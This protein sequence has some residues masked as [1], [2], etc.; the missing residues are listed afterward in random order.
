MR[1][2][3]ATLA[4]L[5][6]LVLA[7]P[8]AVFADDC[9]KPRQSVEAARDAR[10]KAANR[11]ALLRYKA[12]HDLFDLRLCRPEW[13]CPF[14]TELQAEREQIVASAQLQGVASALAAVGSSVNVVVGDALLDALVAP[15]KDE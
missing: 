9:F 10:E 7:A 4:V 15:F 1:A 11:Y 2:L 3:R 13:G 6:C 14:Q 5:L 8:P 12:D